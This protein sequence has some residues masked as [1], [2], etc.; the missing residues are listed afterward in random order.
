MRHRVERIRWPVAALAGV[1]VVGSGTAYAVTRDGTTAH[2]RTV[3]ASKADVEQV[4]S[5]SGTVDAAHRADL[6]FGTSGT[7]ASVAVAVGDTVKAG[8]VVA[9]L[10]TASLESAVTKARAAVAKAVAQLASDRTAQAQAVS[11]A[12]AT[13]SKPSQPTKPT[14]PQGTSPTGSTSGATAAA[15]QQL[16]QEQAAVLQAQ[17]AATAAIAAAKD[18]L[19]AQTTACA[20]AYQ[21]TPPSGSGTGQDA[22]SSQAA[23][24]SACT[25]ALA[26]VQARQADVSAAQDDL[27]KALATL[28]D[29]L[30]QALATLSSSSASPGGASPS[31]ARTAAQ[32]PARSAATSNPTNGADASNGA[33]SGTVTAARL[34]SDQASIEQAR[35][36][37]V[38]A[39]LQL[40]QAVLRSTRSGRVVSVPVGTGDR[41]SAGDV[42]AVVV[43][44]KA[45]TVEASIPQTK[46]GEVH[47]GETVRVTTPAQSGA[48]D[49]RVTAIGLVADSSSGTPSYTVTVTVEDPTIS[50]P[51]GSQALLAIVVATAKDVVTVPTSAITRRGTQATVSTW[52]GTT[53]TRKD[54]TL[55]TVGARQ[56]EVTA[57][58]SA[59][60]R[61]VLADLDQAI[62]GAADKV[63]D[64]GGFSGPVNFKGGG[65]GGPPVTFRS[66]R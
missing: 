15:L 2:Y 60:D 63:N 54:V 17:S 16:K 24:D 43:G 65:P 23:N 11:D 58:L 26:D 52:D 35:A 42:G 31:S 45:V 61:V 39:R 55:G 49:G 3:R 57:G 33:T 4:L 40:R 19:A 10:D 36:D 41:V 5:S 27:Q 14:K 34:A 47:V 22:T 8:Q 20:G 37:L 64:R 51:A 38:D 25:A 9:R 66:A 13:P 62:T 7:V 6:G 50:L 53:L 48:A 21:D 44:G 18:A 1:L 12:A 29:T 32:S 28:A 59:G 46:I 30:T 56:V